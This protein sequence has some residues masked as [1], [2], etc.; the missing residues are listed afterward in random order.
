MTASRSRVEPTALTIGERQKRSHR[1]YFCYMFQNRHIDLLQV[2]QVMNER[3]HVS[4]A[5][6][7]F[8][9]KTSRNN[10]RQ[11]RRNIRLNFVQTRYVPAQMLRHDSEITIAAERRP[12][13]QQL[14]QH[15][16]DGVDIGAHVAPLALN[17]LGRHVIR[18]SRSAA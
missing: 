15:C 16:S 5:V 2:V 6:F 13:R 7:R 17:L 4:V 18:R 12:P 1:R 8:S 10:R 14:E 9:L 3:M 11:L